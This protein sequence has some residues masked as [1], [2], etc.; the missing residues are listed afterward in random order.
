MATLK[1]LDGLLFS[2]SGVGD[3]LWQISDAASTLD[4]SVNFDL[5]SAGEAFRSP[6][7]A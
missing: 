5:P 6:P 2:G 3:G 4:Q 1:L 7:S